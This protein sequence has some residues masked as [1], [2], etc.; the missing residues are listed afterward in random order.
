MYNAALVIFFLLYVYALVKRPIAKWFFK[1]GVP[2]DQANDAEIAV[3][4][5]SLVFFCFIMLALPG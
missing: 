4:F 1:R 3:L 2:F 5:S